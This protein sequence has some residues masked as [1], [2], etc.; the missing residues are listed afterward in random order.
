MKKLKSFDVTIKHLQ[1]LNTYKEAMEYLQQ[2]EVK[3]LR[4]LAAD[5]N[6]ALN[7]KLDKSDLKHI[8]Y[9]NTLLLLGTPYIDKSWNELVAL[10]SQDLVIYLSKLPEN[11]LSAI[12]EKM[13]LNLSDF[14]SQSIIKS[15]I[16]NYA[17]CTCGSRLT[18]CICK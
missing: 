8:I 13:Q 9:I 1:G 18:N 16:S 6:L 2:L 4:C 14:S 17:K 5:M 7:V 15:I 12:A 10:N 3:Q 11:C